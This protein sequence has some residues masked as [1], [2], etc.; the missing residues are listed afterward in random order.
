MIFSALRVAL[1][2][3]SLALDVFAVCIGVGVRGTPPGA[4]IRI[5]LA[6]AAAEIGMNVIGAS[7]GKAAGVMLG[8]VAGYLGFAALVGVG[9]YMIFE[10]LRE[11]ETHFDLSHGWGLFIA[12]LS[13]SLD[14]LGVGFSIVYLG[15]P[16]P[17]TLAAIAL[18]SVVAT[19][20]GLRFG[21]V[22]GERA[23][24]RA[25]L[26]GGIALVATGLLFAALKYFHIA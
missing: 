23:E 25:G 20:L 7:L 10:T 6:F 16:V 14:S 11:S 12:S 19:T 13:I 4:K 5:G 18:A 22:L 2:A 21:S 3:L 15:V 17:V 9:A 1:V 8:D 24:E 26:L